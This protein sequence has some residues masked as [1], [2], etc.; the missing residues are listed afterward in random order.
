MRLLCLT[1][2][3]ERPRPDVLLLFY[4]YCTPTCFSPIIAE[5]YCRNVTNWKHTLDCCV[6]SERMEILKGQRRLSNV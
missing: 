1:S 6:F 5:A 4:G 2:A 3:K